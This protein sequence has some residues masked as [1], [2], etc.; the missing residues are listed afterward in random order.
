MAENWGQSQDPGKMSRTGRA[1]GK[2]NRPGLVPFLA[3]EFFHLP[4]PAFRAQ[5]LGTGR[6][7]SGLYQKEG[8]GQGAGG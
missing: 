6:N 3:P 7:S 1:A 8:R 4:K 5:G 2:P